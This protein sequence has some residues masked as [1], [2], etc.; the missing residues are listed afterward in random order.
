M[1][2]DRPYRIFISTGE[3]SGDLQGGLLVQALQRRAEALGL[4]L[5]IPALGGDRMAAAGA[6]L[7][8]NTMGLGSVGLVESLSFVVPSWQVHQ[9][10]KAYLRRHPP[11]L[12]ILIDYMG[13]NL[14]LGRF[15]RRYLPGVP[16][17]YYIAPQ[18]WVWTWGK[19]NT[20]AIA[21]IPQEILAIFPDEAH[22]YE[23]Q[24]ARVTWVGHPL[25]DRLDTYPDRATA[26]AHLGL[27]PHTPLVALLPAS[28]F[29]E[30][31]YLLPVLCQAAQRIQAAIP[32]VQFY[33][34]LSQAAFQEPLQR[35]IADY[36]LQAQVWPGDSQWVMAAADVALTK[37]GTVNLELAL[38]NIPQVVIYRLSPITA[39]IARHVLR[40][41][42]P[43]AAPPNLVLHRAAVP[44]L[45]QDAATGEAI[46]TAALD[47][48]T[49]SQRRGQ[50]LSDYQELRSALGAPG[51]CDRVA[52]HLLAYL[53]T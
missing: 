5:E 41:S 1:V 28:R 49:N 13:P 44:E 43:F 6:T 11:D 34:P 52:A 53:Q 8:G 48:L 21:Q 47:L 20:S 38:Q 39:W 32:Q 22:Y 40:F 17:V 15:V 23:K 24:G 45:L 50:M 19:S 46:A 33:I 2:R 12:V 10:A 25:L 16:L 4:P 3:V 51:V 37:S 31:T 30:L 27:D 36:G 42:I 9:R 14:S 35:A 29:Q 7:V 26:R 18:E